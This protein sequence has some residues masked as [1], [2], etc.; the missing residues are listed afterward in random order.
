M[1]TPPR[2]YL[3]Y[4]L[5]ALAARTELM[6]RA[7]EFE[8]TGGQAALRMEPKEDIA[9]REVRLARDLGR[10]E[11]N[12]A[13]LIMDALFAENRRIL[14]EVEARRVDTGAKAALW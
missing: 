9:A 12:E 13:R 3:G 11:R 5:A 2:G 10:G 14:D 8:A 6:L 1:C 7:A 4:E